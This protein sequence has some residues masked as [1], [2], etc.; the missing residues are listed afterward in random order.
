MIISIGWKNIWRNRTRSLVVIIAVLLGIFGGVMAAGITTGW[1]SQRLQDSIHKEISHVQVH[2]PKYMNNEDVKSYIHNYD[3]LTSTLDTMQNVVAYSLR[4]KV[5][6]YAQTDWGNAGIML[7]GIDPE[8]EKQVSQLYKN[9]I[10]G[11]YFESDKGTASIVIGSKMAEN[12]KLKNFQITEE[13]L[14]K[15]DSLNMPDTLIA[16]LSNVKRKRFRNEKDFSDELAKN[17]N[18]AEMKEYGTHLISYFSFFRLGTN[19]NVTLQ[20]LNGPL[21]RPTFKVRGIYQ[22]SNTMFDGFNA[23]V[24]RDELNKQLGLGPAKVH[25]IAIISIDNEAG[26]KLAE[27]LLKIYPDQSILSW[28]D[29]SPEL[30]MY[31]DFGKL[32]NYIYVT[33]ILF[34]LAFGIINT[35]LMSVL[36][37]IK[38]LGML[39]AIG[40]NKKKVFGMIMIESIFLSLTGAMAGMIFSGILIVI[41]GK[42][43]I[44][45]GMW[46]EGFEALGYASV[47]YPKVTA[48]TFAGITLL[49]IFTGII[50]SIW[51]ARKALKLNP[52]D[53]IR[54]DM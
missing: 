18:K 38:E 20:S 49:V 31:A 37:R 34:A 14:N 52:A 42:T 5:F 8:K 51:P 35:M 13:K 41:L 26:H 40:M 54:S 19:V 53:A 21:V 32:F 7:K 9:I 28:K 25:E 23:F 39:M 3:S 47:V 27:T 50:A 45:F 4:T 44:N 33:I 1:I 48:D 16:K 17:L 2:N 43:G 22:T 6:A 36:E 12:L 11:D 15:I 10:E 24:K 46:A 29:I 30:A